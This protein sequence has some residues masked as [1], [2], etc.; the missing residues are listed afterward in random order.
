MARNPPFLLCSNIAMIMA[1]TW[2]VHHFQAIFAT[3]LLYKCDV[4]RKSAVT[5]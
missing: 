5:H 1:E 3:L 2:L 4:V